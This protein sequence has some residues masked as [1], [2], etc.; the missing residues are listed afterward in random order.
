MELDPIGL[1]EIGPAD[2]SQIDL[3]LGFIVNEM[4]SVYAKN[5]PV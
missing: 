1:T 4:T 5:R 2:L 3:E